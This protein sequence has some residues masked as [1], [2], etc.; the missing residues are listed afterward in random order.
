M[1]AKQKPKGATV[2]PSVHV[3][4]DQTV[5][6]PAFKI[7]SG[8]GT[9]TGCGAVLVSE[10]WLDCLSINTALASHYIP[11]GPL[12]RQ[13]QGLQVLAMAQAMAA[14]LLFERAR[15]KRPA[16]L[17]RRIEI[18]KARGGRGKRA[19]LVDK[20]HRTAVLLLHGDSVDSAAAATGFKAS[21][22]SKAGD[23]L[24]RSVRR[25]GFRV[26]FTVRYRE[27]RERQFSGGVFQPLPD[28][29][30]AGWSVQPSAGLPLADGR[31]GKRR[32][33]KLRRVRRARLRRERLA[34]R[35]AKWVPYALQASERAQDKRA[36]RAR[37]RARAN[38]GTGCL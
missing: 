32:V 5:T 27:A 9:G 30:P 15:A 28:Y 26:Q 23:Y 14:R 1:T 13:C 21:G 29:V 34:A 2:A 10:E 12:L 3:W 6:L 35:Q 4:A 8:T 11:A 37:A 7:E 16:L 18:I 20:V 31:G 36:S 22:Q 25:L 19:A 17:A 33:P 24:M 38:K